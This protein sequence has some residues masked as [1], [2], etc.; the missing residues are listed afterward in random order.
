MHGSAADRSVTIAHVSDLHLGAHDASAAW[1]LPADIAAADPT[2]T[3]VTGDSTMRALTGQFRLARALLDRLPTPLLQVLGNHDVPLWNPVERM[4]SPYGGYRSHLTDDL[5]PVLE[6]DGVRVQGL[7]S[8]V[9]WRWKSG[10]VSPRQA[11]RVVETLSDAPATALRVVAM[12]HPPS[13]RGLAGLLGRRRFEQSLARAGVHLVL[14]GHTHVPCVRRA[15]L[16]TP[17][18]GEH[19][20]VEIVAGTATSTRTRGID[21]SWTLIRVDATAMTIEHRRHGPDGWHAGDRATYARPW[22]VR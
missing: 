1:S 22:A 4:A 3:V 19:A 14:A 13:Q 15:V 16:P 17:D 2:V 18:G 8:A 20:V 7:G 5:D 21:R 9:P 11:D 10:W 6:V 12:H